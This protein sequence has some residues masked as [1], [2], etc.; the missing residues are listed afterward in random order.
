MDNKVSYALVG[1]FVIILG[2][3]LIASTLWLVTSREQKVYDTYQAYMKES[4]SGLNKNAPVKYRGVEVGQVR[5]ISLVPERPEEVRLLLNIEQGTPIKQD[6]LATLVTQG[7]TGLA[8]V[9]ITGGSRDAPYLEREEG[10]IYREIKT[11]PS[12]LVRID[13]AISLLLQKFQDVSGVADTLLASLNRVADTANSVLSPE[14]RLAI[15]HILNNLDTLSRVTVAHANTL[16]QS[17][18]NI[19]VTLENTAKISGQV[20]SLFAQLERTLAV[21]ERTLTNAEPAVNAVTQAADTVTHTAKAADTLI[22]VS[23]QGFGKT[24][25]TIAD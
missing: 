22:E 17:F 16:D 7:L 19:A 21:T 20:P 23:Q 25:Q 24:A 5:D 18:V 2:S 10:R 15:T 13:S 14:N 9:E 1:L 3:T 4:V 6:S 8:Y 12:L 11:K